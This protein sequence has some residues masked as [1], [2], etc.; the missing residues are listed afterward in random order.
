MSSTQV[1]GSA[2]RGAARVRA[3]DPWLLGVATLTALA[4]LLRALV[5]DQTVVGD[6]LYLFE[7]V[8]DHGL[9]E[10][11]SI[12]HDTESTPPLHFVLAWAM[13]QVGGD[14]FLWMRVPSIVLGTATVPLVYALGMRTVGRTA[15]LIGAAFFALAPFNIFYATE[16]RAYATLAFLCALS[17]LCLVELLR[18]GRTRWAVGLGL[19]TVAAMYTHYTAIFVLVAQLVWALAT[20]R[21]RSRSVLLAYGAAVLAYLPWVPSLVFQSDDS[22]ADRVEALYPLTPRSYV[23]G[24][25]KAWL[26]HP[27]ASLRET[28]SLPG[29]ALIV[30]GLVGAAAAAVIGAL[31]GHRGPVRPEVILVALLA[32]ATPVCALLFS[33]GP[34]SIFTPRYLSASLPAAALATGMLLS[35]TRRPLIVSAAA[36]A[37]L[38]GLGI[39]AIRAVQEDSRRPAYRDIAH[40]L[41]RVARPED[42]V[43]ELSIFTGPPSRQ[44]SYY[45]RRSHRYF[46]SRRS[47]DPAY[48][49][50]RRSGRIFVVIPTSGLKSYLPFLGM[51]EHGFRLAKRRL[52]PGVPDLAL[53]TYV[54]RES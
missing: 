32:L 23:A 47:L 15:A 9:G 17:T 52:Y 46:P 40:E 12:V 33:L 10:V 14:D 50:G 20:H 7:I 5:I 53:L 19:A 13:T 30:L 54:P 45:F 44:L 18:T 26:G 25:A 41:D 38:V 1:W 39:G 21:D 11:L 43:V 42:P 3:G 48:A 36:G 28:L 8:H 37:L 29:V 24:L 6:E 2:A 31:R 27:Y 49:L 34:A 51:R 4:F 22:A 35:A 16:G